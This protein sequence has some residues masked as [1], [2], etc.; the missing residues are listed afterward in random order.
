MPGAVS[1]ALLEELA[2]LTAHNLLPVGNLSSPSRRRPEQL[3][4]V[5][6]LT[7]RSS[8]SSPSSG[9]PPPPLLPP[10]TGSQVTCFTTTEVQ[11][12][13]REELGEG[14]QLLHMWAKRRLPCCRGMRRESGRPT[15][16]RPLSRT[17]M[18]LLLPRCLRRCWANASSS[19]A[20]QSSLSSTGAQAR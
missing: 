6:G 5:A 19:P 11:I 10:A 20:S 15:C 18:V 7:S 3:D 14:L 13:T 2:F 8:L 9:P 12:L 1:A 17:R 4:R 16:A